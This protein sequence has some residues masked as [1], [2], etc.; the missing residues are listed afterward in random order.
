MKKILPYI[1][2]FSLAFF[3]TPVIGNLVIKK[4]NDQA[5]TL[6]KNFYLNTS[7]L[8]DGF[9]Q[10]KFKIFK[11]ITLSH[12]EFT[13]KNHTVENLE[14]KRMFYMP[15]YLSKKDIE[16]NLKNAQNLALDALTGATRPSNFAKAAIIDAI[17]NQNSK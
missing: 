12:V 9:Y 4:A 13:I 17:E 16:E 8:A 7:N 2:V 10:G 5:N 1:L 3:A 14:F 11:L 15:G 6:A